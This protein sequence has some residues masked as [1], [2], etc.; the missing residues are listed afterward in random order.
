MDNLYP[1]FKSDA[2]VQPSGPAR[3]F[4]G[5]SQDLDDLRSWLGTPRAPSQIVSISGIGGIGKTTLMSEMAEVCRRAS[6]KVVWLDGR[7]FARRSTDFLSGIEMI[8]EQEYGASRQGTASTLDSI[9]RFFETHRTVVFIDNCEDLTS[10]EGW[11]LSRFIPQ[12]PKHNHLFVLASKSGLPLSWRTNPTTHGLMRSRTLHLFTTS[13]AKDY[14][15]YHKIPTTMMETIIAR[16]QGHPLSLAL[17]VDAF[18]NQNPENALHLV[19]NIPNLV[20][21]EILQEVTSPSIFEALQVLSILSDARFADLHNL[22]PSFQIGDYRQLSKLSFVR[23]VGQELTMHDVVARMLR[24]DF[25]TRDKRAF[26]AYCRRAMMY[27]AA[28]YASVEKRTQMRIA[29]R[30][31]TLYLE[32]MPMRYAYADFPF[33]PRFDEYRGFQMDD[34]PH[35][36]RILEGAMA[37]GTWQCELIRPGTHHAL[38]DDIAKHCPEGIRVVRSE[39]NVPLTLGAA[40]WLRPDTVSLLQRYAPRFITEVLGR[41]PAGDSEPARGP[42]RAP[43]PA[44]D[45]QSTGDSEPERA[46]ESTGDSEPAEFNWARQALNNLPQDDPDSLCVLLAA[47]DMEHPVYRPEVLGVLSFQDWYKVVSTGVRSLVATRDAHLIHLSTE[48]GYRKIQQLPNFGQEDISILELDFRNEKFPVWARAMLQQMEDQ[49][50]DGGGDGGRSQERDRD[51]DGGRSQ[52]RDQ[53]RDRQQGQHRDRPSGGEE[54]RPQTSL[55]GVEG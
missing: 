3:S 43:E 13:E 30:F 26:Q 1:L 11:L 12:L 17:A 7:T 24:Q 38:L 31:L 21:A 10:V 54:E 33:A 2:P 53:D 23:A 15:N 50:L 22:I 25:Q 47:V 16:A 48:F 8:L 36:H 41:E 20:S 46:R 14:L 6:V 32:L 45:S 29:A 49:D 5:R 42:A 19:E 51:G 55:A 37:K 52:D 39:T 44:G 34:L 28:Q 18:H 27:L 40:I 35:L 9:L 4:I